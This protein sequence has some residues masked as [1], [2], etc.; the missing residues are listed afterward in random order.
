MEI[1]IGATNWGNRALGDTS[2]DAG[3]IT[4]VMEDCGEVRQ[5]LGIRG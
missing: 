2:D 4:E 3:N 1:Q 5:L